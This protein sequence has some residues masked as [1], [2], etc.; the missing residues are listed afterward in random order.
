MPPGF[1]VSTTAYREF[2][3]SNRL[4]TLIQQALEG[5]APDDTNELENA[6]QT[7]R[8][9]FAQGDL[10][11]RVHLEIQS[12]YEELNQQSGLDTPSTSIRATRPPCF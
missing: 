2:V 7:I 1:I 9:A 5:L 6:S 8:S 3:K 4:D 12:A 10:P 11:A